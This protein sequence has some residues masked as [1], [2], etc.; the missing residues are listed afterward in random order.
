MR[1]ARSAGKHRISKDSSRHVI[2]HYRARFEEPPPPDSPASG[3]IR[4]VYLGEDAHGRALE[5]MAVERDSGDLLVIHAMPLRE[6]YRKRYE[7]APR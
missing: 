3:S 6:K 4:I 1:F 2:A 5:V 7:E